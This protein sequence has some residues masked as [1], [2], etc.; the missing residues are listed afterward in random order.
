MAPTALADDGIL[1]SAQGRDAYSRPLPSLETGRGEAFRHGRSL[2][3]QAWLLAPSAESAGLDGLGPLFNR[4]SC[5]ACHVKNGRGEPPDGAGDVMRSTLLRLGL[6]GAGPHGEPAPH[7]VYGDQLN[8]DGIPGVPGEGKATLVWHE[9]E[10]TL[11]GGET[12]R[13]RRP[14]VL[15]RDLAYGPLGADVLTSVRLAPPV[16]GLGLLEAVPE[17][18]ILALAAGNGGRPNMV[19]D[20]TKGASA[21]GRFGLKANQPSLRQQNAGALAGDIGITSTLFPDE[22]CT[23]AQ[24]ACR[25]AANPRRPELTD[26]QL[27][28]LTL[29]VQALAVPERRNADDPVVRAGGRLFADLGCASCHAPTLTTGP[30]ALPELAGRTIHPYTDL[31][32]HDLG[33]GLADG[34]PDFLA[35]GREWRTPPLWGIGLAEPIAGRAFYLHDGRARTLGEAILWHGGQAQP[36]RDAFRDLPPERRAELLAFIRSL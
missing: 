19:W 28:A 9:R 13:L 31:L 12:V 2:F 35:T 34:R 3:R 32:L 1:V 10:E 33:D 16:F 14:E 4:L 11:A 23:A 15:L 24:T 30:H 6:P 22:A 26:A 21:L 8:P 36:A 27:D 29:Y 20:V 7:P 17:S 18:A 5:I 25:A